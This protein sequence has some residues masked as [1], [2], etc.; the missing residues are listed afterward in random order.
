MTATPRSRPSRHASERR[1]DGAGPAAVPLTRRVPARD[2]PVAGLRDGLDEPRPR[3]VV[4]ELAPQ[5]RDVDVDDPV[6]D[7]VRAARD[8]LEKLVAGQHR[9]RPA[10]ERGEQAQLTRREA[11]P[12]RRSVRLARPGRRV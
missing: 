1:L 4:A 3:R 9:A 6:V 5:V 11:A 8:G 10:G 12:G 2:Q 7:L